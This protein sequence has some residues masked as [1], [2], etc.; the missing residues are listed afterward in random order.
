MSKPFNHW[1]DAIEVFTIQGDTEYHKHSVTDADNFLRVLEDKQDDV[2]SQVDSERK[3]QI[4]E[5]RAKLV[6]I[7]ETIILCGR[8]ELSLRGT[9]EAG[10][11]LVSGV[12]AND[13]NFRAM[14]RFRVS[15]GDTGLRDHLQSA[16]MYTSP[17]IQNQLIEVC[18]EL[19]QTEIVNKVNKA[20]CFSVL[21]DETADVSGIE[22]MSLCVR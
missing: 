18:G 7:V 5:N 13:G 22:Q 8:Q 15:A 1:K 6:P 20:K 9:G 14:L 16:A 10:P 11:V 19:I 2:L 17:T 3:R 4:V 21:A 12:H